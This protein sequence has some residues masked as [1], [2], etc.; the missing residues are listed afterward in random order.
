[1]D[2]T[3]WPKLDVHLRL[4]LI[5]WQELAAA[6]RA[7]PERG[8]F[9]VYSSIGCSDLTTYRYISIIN[10]TSSWSCSF[11]NPS[12]ILFPVILIILDHLHLLESK[13][14]L[15]CWLFVI[16]FIQAF[17]HILLDWSAVSSAYSD[18]VHFKGDRFRLQRKVINN[19]DHGWHSWAKWF[20][21]TGRR[22]KATTR[23]SAR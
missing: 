12:F 7:R 21:Y 9:F 3:G 15:L 19:H 22:P 13:I 2:R 6:D 8:D 14:T 16:L 18:R 23:C 11:S 20:K 4:N 1:M 17:V 5:E 10:R